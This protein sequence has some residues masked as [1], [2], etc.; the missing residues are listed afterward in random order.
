MI[1]RV[2]KLDLLGWNKSLL[3]WRDQY[4][5][6]HKYQ[7]KDSQNRSFSEKSNGIYETYKNTVMRHDHHIYSK[8]SDV[9]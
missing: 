1:A 6:K 4:F 9:E 5:F 3:L 8:A 7:I 2:E